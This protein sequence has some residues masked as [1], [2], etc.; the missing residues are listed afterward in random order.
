MITGNNI[1]DKGIKHISDVIASV[2]FPLENLDISNNNISNSGGILFSKALSKNSSLL[3]LNMQM[4]ELKTE[5]G[6]AIKEAVGEHRTLIKV[7]LE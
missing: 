4:N 2:T 7:C 6:L 3:R 1:G 5:A